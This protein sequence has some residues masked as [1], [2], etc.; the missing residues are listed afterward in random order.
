MT[1]GPLSSYLPVH[2]M[3]EDLWI[4]AQRAEV[5]IE[6]NRT[7]SDRGIDEFCDAIREDPDSAEY[8]ACLVSA[9]PKEPKTGT[10]P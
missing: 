5:L 6:G 4:G 3:I 2:L 10:I 8:I 1:M 7:W 9:A